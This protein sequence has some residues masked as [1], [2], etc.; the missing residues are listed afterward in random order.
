VVAETPP[1]SD[2]FLWVEFDTVV[3]TR[4][5]LSRQ[6]MECDNPRP[7]TTIKPNHVSSSQI[8][9]QGKHTVDQKG[10]CHSAVSKMPQLRA[11]RL[12]GGI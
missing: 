9:W 6:L 7:P 5:K 1:E 11:F 10:T 2:K 8:H 3:E 4:G 12:T